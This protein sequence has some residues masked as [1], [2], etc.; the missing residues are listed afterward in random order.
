MSDLSDVSAELLRAV[1][2]FPEWPKD[3]LHALAIVGEEYGELTKAVL[4]HTYE[5]KKGVTRED[6]REEAIQT[7]AM[8]L[9]FIMNLDDYTYS[10]SGMLRHER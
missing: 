10:C 9:R 3:P 1:R 6:I 5:P 2:K 8:I 4:Q 7:A